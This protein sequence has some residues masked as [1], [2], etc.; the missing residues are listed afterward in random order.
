MRYDSAPAGVNANLTAN[1]ATGGA[2]NDT[3]DELGGPIEN[4]VGSQ[5]QRRPR[6]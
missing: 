1:T 2:G 6:R 4:L 5:L 3:F